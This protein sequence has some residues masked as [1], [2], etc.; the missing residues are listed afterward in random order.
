MFYSI[1]ERARERESQFFLILPSP[2][3]QS[4]TKCKC[5]RSLCVKTSPLFSFT[6]FDLLIRAHYAVLESRGVA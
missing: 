4:A 5:F 2:G 6:L 3:S 1:Y